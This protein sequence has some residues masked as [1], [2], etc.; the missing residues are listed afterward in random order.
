MPKYNLALLPVSCS[1]DVIN[2]ANK[3]SLPA[4]NYC[5]GERSLPHITLYQ[6]RTEAIELDRI[7][8]QICSVWDQ[9]LI[10]LTLNQFSC[11]TFDDN[12]FFISLLPDHRDDLH[13]M[14]CLIADTFKWPVKKLFDPHMSLMNTLDREC[15][16]EAAKLAALYTPIT[17]RF[18][19]SLGISDEVG[20]FME[21]VYSQER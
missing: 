1:H 3:L 18:Y 21:T 11:V 19:L 14:H 4:N 7:W 20:Q 16:K 6:F 17:D 12:N 10:E 2:L 5:L 9:K 8:N 15:E 13:N